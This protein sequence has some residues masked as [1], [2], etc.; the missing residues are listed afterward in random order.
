MPNRL[1]LAESLF[2]VQAFFNAISDH[3][4]LQ[5][6]DCLSKGVSYGIND[7][8]CSFSADLEPGDDPFEGVCFE[9][10]NEEVVLSNEELFEFVKLVCADFVKQ[11]PDQRADI[12]NSLVRFQA[13]LMR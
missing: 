9:L 8:H 5:V 4:F 1:K 2:P 6:I 11:Y 3:S 12:E 10:F 7:C 13:N